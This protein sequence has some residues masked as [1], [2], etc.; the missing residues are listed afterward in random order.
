MTILVHKIHTK[1][2]WFQGHVKTYGS[3]DKPMVQMTH[4][5]YGS[6]DRLWSKNVHGKTMSS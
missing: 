6:N 1:N 5:T 3:D 2:L 4:K